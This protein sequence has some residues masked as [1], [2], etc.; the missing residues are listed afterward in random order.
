MFRSGTTAQVHWLDAT[1][2][3]RQEVLD[4]SFPGRAVETYGWTVDGTK[5]LARVE[6]PSSAPVYYLIDFTS[7]RADIAAEEY[8]ALADVKLGELKQLTY[9]ARDGTDIPAYLTVPPERAAGPGPLIVMPHG[10]PNERDY[11][12]F[13]WLVQFLVSRGYSVLQPQFR[14]ST[15]FGA[16]FER[17]G[18]RQWGGLMQDD[19]TDGVRA[20]IAQGIADPHRICIVGMSYGGYA[21][22]AGAAFTPELYACAISVNGV[23]DL[24][25]LLSET[26]PQPAIGAHVI[27]AASSVWRERIGS[28]G[29]RL[30]D[31][32]SPI[33]AVAAVKAPILVIYGNSDGVV[34]IEQSIRMSQ[35]LKEAGKKVELVK[36][37]DEDHWLSHTAS[38]IQMLQ[39]FEAF[40]RDNL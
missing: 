26:T 3:H 34:P 30:L 9:K 18:Y 6:S 7:H 4:R 16:A 28:V 32:K 5:V 20:M 36:L 14:G 29:D 17:A 12:T 13:D 35:A 31:T 11:P 19:V 33:H 37:P 39:A 38:R 10:G 15:G 25:A 8:P 24:R 40:L 23:S 27:S 21:A 22:L 1:A 2:Q